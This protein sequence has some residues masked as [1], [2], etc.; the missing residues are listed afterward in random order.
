MA[1]SRIYTR[2]SHI[3]E[4]VRKTKHPTATAIVKYLHGLGERVDVRTVQ[5]DIERISLDMDIE[6]TK[7]GTHPRHWYEIDSEPEERPVASTYLEYAMMTDI[8][9]KEVE[10]EKKHGKV[11]FLDYPVMTS[12]LNNIPLT[13]PG[14]KGEKHGKHDLPEVQW[15]RVGA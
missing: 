1:Y 12:G 7:R 14:H 15:R 8:M 5:R 2:H 3:V 6:I 13:N 11:I 9:R 4:F 10:D